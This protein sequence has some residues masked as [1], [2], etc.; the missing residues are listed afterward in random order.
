MKSGGDPSASIYDVKIYLGLCDSDQLGGTFDD[1]W[2]PW[3]KTLVVDEPVESFTCS[4][5][6]WFEIPLEA[7][8]WYGGN[9]NLLVEVVF[10]G[11]SSSLLYNYNWMAGTARSVRSDIYTDSAGVV[12]P[13]VSH[14]TLVGE[15]GLEAST[16][17]G[18]KA[19]G[20]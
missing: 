11:G 1:N 3:S 9:E 7:P 18:I 6:E 5:G 2:I 15:A 19:L 14:L 20:L 17:G 16:F 4:A 8:W 12:S 13:A 10:H